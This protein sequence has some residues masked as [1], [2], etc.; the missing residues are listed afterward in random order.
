MN[1]LVAEFNANLQATNIDP[2]HEQTPTY[3]VLMCSDSRVNVAHML[4]CDTYNKVFAI[5]NAG[6]TVNE[7][8]LWTIFYALH[9]AKVKQFIVLGHSFCGACKYALETKCG[10][11]EP[12][13]DTELEELQH[14]GATCSCAEELEKKNIQSQVDKLRDTFPEHAEKIMG[15]YYHLKEKRVEQVG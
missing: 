7:R 3:G 13:L 9:H 8:N 1:N 11:G 12:L 5:E 2:V 4:W 10:C 14:I 15:M 6:N